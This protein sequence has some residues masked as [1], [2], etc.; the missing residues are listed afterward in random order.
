MRGRLIDRLVGRSISYRLHCSVFLYYVLTH[1][2][3]HKKTSRLMSLDAKMR[4]IPIGNEDVNWLAE[5]FDILKFLQFHRTCE[6]VLCRIRQYSHSNQC[7]Q[8]ITAFSLSRTSPFSVILLSHNL[9]QRI[10]RMSRCWKN[11]IAFIFIVDVRRSDSRWCSSS[12][13]QRLFLNQFT[14]ENSL[15]QSTLIAESTASI[16]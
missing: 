7:R 16:W 13:F 8:S 12:L 15:S 5:A 3:T 10:V 11:V 2:L 14:L 9:F 1:E 4:H 6:V